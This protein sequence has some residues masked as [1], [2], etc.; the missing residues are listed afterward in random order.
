MRAILLRSNEKDSRVKANLPSLATTTQP[1]ERTDLEVRLLPPYNVI[2]YN[3]DYHSME[4]VVAVLMK[5]M[6]FSIQQA[7]LRMLEAHETGR[8]VIWTGSKEVAEL[9]AEQIHT[10]HEK[11][12]GADL[13]PLA[14]EIE[15]APC[16]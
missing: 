1:R 11:R 14:V 3:D 4:F 5:V 10:L 2:L 12:Q 15:P 16:A 13:G 6:N 9:K 8:A 7:M